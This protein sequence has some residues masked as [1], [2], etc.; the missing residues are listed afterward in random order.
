LTR[1]P[2]KVLAKLASTCDTGDMDR[3]EAVTAL[4]QAEHLSGRSRAAGR[5]YARY[6]VL[7]GLAGIALAVGV[8]R[9]NGWPGTLIVTG[10]YLG[11]VAVITVWAVTRPAVMA[12]MGRLHGMAVGGSMALWGMTVGLGTTLFR[13]QPGWWLAGGL[14]MAVPAFIGAAIAFRRTRV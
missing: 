8:G 1:R 10:L 7:F 9:F 12:G 11:F 4:A 14:A 3:T 5:W 13:D 2:R 6:L